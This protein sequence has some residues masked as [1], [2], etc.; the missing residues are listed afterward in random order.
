VCEQHRNLIGDNCSNLACE[1]KEFKS[2]FYK[3]GTMLLQD[4]RVLHRIGLKDLNGVNTVGV[5]WF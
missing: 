4:E 5:M 2:A 1:L 3:K